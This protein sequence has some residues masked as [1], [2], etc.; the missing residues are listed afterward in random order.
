MKN[1]MHKDDRLMMFHAG[2]AGHQLGKHARYAGTIC[3][4]FCAIKLINHF[5]KLVAKRNNELYGMVLFFFNRLN[6]S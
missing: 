3:I 2:M 1:R 5:I 4:F 6:G